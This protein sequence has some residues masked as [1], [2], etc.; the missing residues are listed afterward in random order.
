ME[1][2]SPPS[3]KKYLNLGD[4]IVGPYE[5]LDGTSGLVNDY[6]THEKYTVVD[7]EGN[8]KDIVYAIGV[9]NDGTTFSYN[10]RPDRSKALARDIEKG[11]FPPYHPIEIYSPSDLNTQ[12]AKYADTSQAAQV[13]QEIHNLNIPVKMYTFEEDEREYSV[14]SINE[15]DARD[16]IAVLLDK[17]PGDLARPKIEDLTEE[18]I[19]P[20]VKESENL[21]EC[22]KDRYAQQP[23]QDLLRRLRPTRDIEVHI[24]SYIPLGGKTPE[25]DYILTH[26]QRKAQKIFLQR[27]PEPSS[28]QYLT[29]CTV[30]AKNLSKIFSSPEEA[31]KAL[32]GAMIDR[33]F[34][35]KPST[36]AIQ[37]DR[38]SQF[39]Y[40]R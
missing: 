9:D 40:G 18:N 38:R 25:N 31:E 29:S 13:L 22:I 2:S 35:L 14:P 17:K 15:D 4:Q 33:K 27:H 11:I 7:Y 5:R 37:K 28:Y 20:S 19:Y 8:S 10:I 32:A 3:P 36:R 30:V 39:S 23:Y 21:L 6:F 24:F 26:D 34:S 1:G 16:R 12:I